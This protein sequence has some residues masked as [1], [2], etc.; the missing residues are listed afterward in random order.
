ML[1]D[2]KKK[3]SFIGEIYVLPDFDV[4]KRQIKNEPIL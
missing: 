1:R 2:L 4:K 3:W